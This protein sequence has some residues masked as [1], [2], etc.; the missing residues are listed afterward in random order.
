M[1]PHVHTNFRGPPSWLWRKCNQLLR[2]GR[3][4]GAVTLSR[5]CERWYIERWGA[6]RGLKSRSNNY[7][8]H[9][10]HGDP[11]PTRKI[12][13][14]EPG[15]EPGSSWLVVRSS[16]QRGWSGNN[17]RW[18]KK[19][20]KKPHDSEC[21][22]NVLWGRS[23]G[24]ALERYVAAGWVKKCRENFTKIILEIVAKH[25]VLPWVRDEDNIQNVFFKTIELGYDR[26][27]RWV[28]WLT[29]WPRNFLLNFS[30]PCI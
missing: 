11:P 3:P 17:L 24:G 28:Y 4:W 14:V 2:L 19:S 16:D 15:I 18:D 20:D 25:F 6:R 8:D 22:P 21:L 27:Q 26:F 9:G 30:T 10:H 23:N 7:P 1:P 13:I 12:P 29:L 5:W